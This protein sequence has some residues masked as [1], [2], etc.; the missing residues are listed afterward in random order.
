MKLY[1]LMFCFFDT[2]QSIVFSYLFI[3]FWIKNLRPSTPDYMCTFSCWELQV[4]RSNRIKKISRNEQQLRQLLKISK[5]DYIILNI[6]VRSIYIYIYIYIH[7]RKYV[8]MHSNI[9]PLCQV[10]FK[11]LNT[12]V[13]FRTCY[14]NAFLSN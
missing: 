5:M 2:N 4:I 14:V 7:L 6:H 8:Y 11:K 12:S 13:H 9:T 3:Y 1:G 10:S